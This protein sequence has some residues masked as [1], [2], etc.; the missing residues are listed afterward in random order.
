MDQRTRHAIAIASGVITL[1]LVIWLTITTP[2]DPASLPLGLVFCAL[3]VFTMTF[4]VPLGGGSV[5][6]MP[7]TVVAAYLAIGPVPAVWALLGGTV[8]SA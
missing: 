3:I 4:G 7:M 6:F 2:P 5:S 8:A 1:A